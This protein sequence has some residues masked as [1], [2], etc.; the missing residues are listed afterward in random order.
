MQRSHPPL[1]VVVL[2][3]LELAG[4][5]VSCGSSHASGDAGNQPQDSSSGAEVATPVDAAGGPDLS[6]DGSGLDVK[7]CVEFMTQGPG[8]VCFGSDPAPY[9]MYLS[10]SAASKVG[11]CPTTGD[12][13]HALGEGSIGYTS[14]GP[15][16][17]PSGTPADGAAPQGDGGGGSCCFWV[18]PVQGV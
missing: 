10:G 13:I 12:F 6:T 2:I 4:G 9:Q 11:T 16:T 7:S 5:N 8:L 18:L 3:T 14:C 1:V 15:V 17:P